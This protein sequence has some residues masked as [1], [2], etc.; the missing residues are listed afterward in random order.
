MKCRVFYFFF[1]CFF[2][3]AATDAANAYGDERNIRISG[4]LKSFYTVLDHPTLSGNTTN[5][6][7]P[8]EGIAYIPLRLKLFYQPID[9]VTAEFAY[10][11]IPIIQGTKRSSVYTL[12]PRPEPL[13]YRAIDMRERVYPETLDLQN[14]FVITQNIDR[15]S[16]TYNMPSVDFY[17]G[18]QSI[19]FGS[20]R[21]INPTDIIAPFTYEALSKE[22]RIGVDAI[23]TKVPI[24]DM[25]EFD[26]G[27]VFG[28][29]FKA[30]ESALFLRSK[31][32]FMM[33]D[34]TFMTIVFK[35]NLLF[36]CDIA[37]SIGGA[38]YWLE[39]AYTLAN[40][41]ADYTPEEDYFRL[42]TGIDYNF[43]NGLYAFIEYHFNGAGNLRS[44]NY[45]KSYTETAY[46]DG[47]VYLLGR[48]YIAPG[49]TYEI[50]P[51]LIFNA[52]TLLNVG[53]L[54][55]YLSPMLEFNFTEDIYIELGAFFSMG[56]RATGYETGQDSIKPN[57]EFGLYPDIYFTS[58]RLYF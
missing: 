56:R 51:L 28:D 58:I 43:G 27:I 16:V 39:A 34:L 12:L 41:T 36:G 1:L 44:E 38:G 35:E 17:I 4:Y 26:S 9:Y 57:S 49:L 10:E 55:A 40:I 6:D 13:S 52:Q 46:T 2:A 14:S 53:D 50:T 22:E 54:S 32:Y 37:R 33:T 42:S 11:I 18:R 7:I 48:H 45:L 25:G 15:A 29:E 19:A 24:G 31:V 5:S 3:T 30:K 21:V 8:L 23:R 47:A 20:A